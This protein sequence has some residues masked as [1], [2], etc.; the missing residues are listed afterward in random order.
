[1]GYPKLFHSNLFMTS[2]VK[3]C[4]RHQFKEEGFFTP[5][6]Y[7]S[8]VLWSDFFSFTKYNLFYQYYLKTFGMSL[9][10]RS[11]IVMQPS[12]E[13]PRAKALPDR[14]RRRPFGPQLR[15]ALVFLFQQLS[16]KYH[17]TGY[18]RLLQ[19]TKGYYR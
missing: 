17:A 18:C 1:M 6:Y 16:T 9:R 7:P 11:C 8:P 3:E 13:A 5:S 12:I 15:G 4:I 19:V 2:L 14:A 10:V